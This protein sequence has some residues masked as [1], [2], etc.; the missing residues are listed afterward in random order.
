MTPI[1]GVDY[2]W[3]RPSIPGLAAAGKYFACRYLSYNTT[4]KNLTTGERDALFAAGLAICL[5]WENRS[6]DASDG[7]SG[8]VRN[9]REA[10]RQASALGFPPDRPIYFSI[11]EDTSGT[12]AR[13]DA[14]LK[15]I[16]SVMP[17]ALIGVYGG[18]ATVRRAHEQGLATWLWQTYA[19]SRGAWYAAA[20]VQQYRNGVMVA[21]ADVDLNRAMVTDYGQWTGDADMALTPAE[22]NNLVATD[23]RVRA[24]ITGAPTA[25]YTIDGV[26]RKEPNA[27]AAALAARPAAAVD[28]A[29]LADAVKAAVAAAVPGIAAAV[30][31]LLSGRLAS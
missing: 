12:P 4:G 22:H 3:D 31:D 14:Y 30:A 8:G 1:E 5:N 20:H 21:G 25:E 28:P 11:D 10:L 9:A 18:L 19:W 15:G 26:A 29:L 17:V 23:A 7:Y 27:V 24:I 6:D 13:V 2:A 16:G